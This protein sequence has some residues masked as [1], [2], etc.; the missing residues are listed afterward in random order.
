VVCSTVGF[1]VGEA[2]TLSCTGEGVGSSSS[3]EACLLDPLPFEAFLLEDLG[4]LL[5]ALEL[6]ALELEAL[7]LEALERCVFFELLLLPFPVLDEAFPDLETFA[8]WDFEAFANF[9]LV[10]FSLLADLDKRLSCVLTEE[11]EVPRR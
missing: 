5:E 1:I 2:V 9:D 11:L 6:E 8:D 4:P 10:H 7:E 3:Q